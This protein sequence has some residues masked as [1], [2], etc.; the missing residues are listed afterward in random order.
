ML[1]QAHDF[2]HL[3]ST[4][5]VDLQVGASDQWGNII[6]GVDLIKH[7]EQKTTYAYTW[8]LL[9][10]KSTGKKF[11]KSEG[12]AVWLDPKKTSPFAFYQ[13]WLNSEDDSVEEY[14][15][16]MTLLSLE[17]I[18]DIMKAHG[19]NPGNRIAQKRLAEA[20][21]TLVHGESAL[22]SV[23]RVTEVLFGDTDLATLSADEQSLVR[24]SASVCMVHVGDSV[25]DVLVESA[26]A[27]S[28]REAREFIENGAVTLSGEKMTDLERVIQEEDFN[29]APMLLLKRG[30]RNVCALVRL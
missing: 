29:A 20:V 10:N 28:K 23:A 15:T 1:L 2:W 22:A 8:P 9:V 25:V 14:L 4:M 11:G 6:S 30:K 24:E 16:K 3:Y 18:A 5:G 19:E 7:K 12:G 21:T 26:L 13:F 17:E 27:S